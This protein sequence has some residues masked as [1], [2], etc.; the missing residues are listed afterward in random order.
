MITSQYF[1]LLL[2]YISM[3]QP[4]AY[5]CFLPPEPL[6]HVPPYL[7]LPDC[8]KALALGSLHH[9]LSLLEAFTE[10]LL[11]QAPSEFKM[12]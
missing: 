4:Q 11:Q 12:H 2:P 5:T 6:S 3:N 8:H 1:F 7:I 10:H 9:T